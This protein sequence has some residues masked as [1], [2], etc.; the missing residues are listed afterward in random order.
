MFRNILALLAGYFMMALLTMACVYALTLAMPEYAQAG[1]A[2]TTPPTLAVVLNLLLGIPCAAAGGCLTARL[3]ANRPML[4]AST[5][6]G[7]VI[8]FGIVYWWTGR[9]GPHPE[10]S[11]ALLPVAGALGVLA[12]GGIGARTRAG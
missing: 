10:W 5:L 8:V 11:L 7:L 3:A 2:G 1:Q 12:G 9:D 6:A 4:W